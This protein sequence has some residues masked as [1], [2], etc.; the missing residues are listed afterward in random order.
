MRRREIAR[1]EGEHAEPLARRQQLQQR[2]DHQQRTG[3]DRHGEARRKLGLIEHEKAAA[4]GD[5]IRAARDQPLAGR[6]EVIDQRRRLRGHDLVDGR[7]AHDLEQRRLAVALRI[8][9]IADE[10]REA[11]VEHQDAEGHGRSL[12]LPSPR[13]RRRSV[14]NGEAA[15]RMRGMRAIRPLTRLAFARRLSRHGERERKQRVAA[16]TSSCTRRR[17]PARRRRPSSAS[18]R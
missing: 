5:R 17:S 9:D 6:D 11:R 18:P 10:A 15:S 12:R 16:A 14:A 8:A 4:G 3:R 2:R 13:L 7:A 1:R